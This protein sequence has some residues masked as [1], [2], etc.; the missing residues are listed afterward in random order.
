ME[1][2]WDETK[3]Q[4]AL[5]NRGLDFADVVEF[6]WRNAVIEPDGRRDYGEQRLIAYGYLHGRLCV[7]CFT[8]R[9]QKLRVISLR[10]AN[11]RE[12][13]RYGSQAQE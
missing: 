8:E 12:I 5:I 2:E 3:R 11:D 9:G 13:K 4:Y 6:G 7:L 1:L 10:K